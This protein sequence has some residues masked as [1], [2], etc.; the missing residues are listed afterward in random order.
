MFAIRSVVALLAGLVLV[1][2]LAAQIS[3]KKAVA[4]LKSATKTE[5]KTFKQAGAD[6]LKALDDSLAG[7]EGQLSESSQPTDVTTDAG[8]AVI[9]FAM[10]VETA[11]ALATTD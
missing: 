10:S 9:A 8:E 11:F 4:E 1:P 2:S 3:E 7:V 6:A 5:L